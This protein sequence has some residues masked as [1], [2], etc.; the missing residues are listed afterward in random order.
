M[1]WLGVLLFGLLVF[2]VFSILNYKRFKTPCLSLIS[3]ALKT[4]KSKFTVYLAV[5]NYKYN[6][7][8]YYFRCILSKLCFVK[9]NSI[10]PLLYSNIPLSC[11]HS[12]FTA[13]ILLRRVR[14]PSKSVCL[15]D[16]ASLLAD[17]MLYKDQEINTRLM[18]FVKLYGHYSH[19]GL[20]FVNTQSIQDLHYSFKR[21]I[22]SY[23]YIH[24]AVKLPFF[25]ILHVIE[26]TY[27]E[28]NSSVN[29][30]IG[31]AEDNLKWVLI[32]NY[33]NKWYDRYCYSI[34]TDGLPY[35]G[36]LDCANTLKA[37]E[38]VTIRKDLN[39]YVS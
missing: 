29:V 36:S 38:I 4:G 11:R 19:G 2:F 25:T 34:F 3:G 27:S 14:I 17:S 6:L 39:D 24:H 21:C 32:P 8:L 22:G 9:S 1:I 35:V 13:D 7:A 20:C 15:I 23:L 12:R 28:D 10:M 26:L 16:E 18:L 37:D 5:Q 31:D 30:N 33:V